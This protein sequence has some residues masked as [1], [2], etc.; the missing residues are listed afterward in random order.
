MPEDALH[1]QLLGDNMRDAL[2][3]VEALNWSHHLAGHFQSLGL[4]QSA[5]WW[6]HHR[7]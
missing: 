5:F 7:T 1:R 2:G 3:H 4:P 6:W